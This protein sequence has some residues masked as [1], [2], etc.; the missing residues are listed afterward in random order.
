MRQTL[1]GGIALAWV[2]SVRIDLVPGLC[3]SLWKLA[4]VN[5]SLDLM[6]CP[7]T[8]ESNAAKDLSGQWTG[9]I[10][11]EAR[12]RPAVPHTTP[13]GFDIVS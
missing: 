10:S 12:N 4:L 5:E 7:R 6:S 1:Y 11:P 3:R 13:Q 8:G 9:I 2:C